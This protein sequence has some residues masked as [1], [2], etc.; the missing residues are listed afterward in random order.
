VPR[1]GVLGPLRG[2][3]AESGTTSSYGL[4]TSPRYPPVSGQKGKQRGAT[5]QLVY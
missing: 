1:W 2:E 3:N 5:V 4:L